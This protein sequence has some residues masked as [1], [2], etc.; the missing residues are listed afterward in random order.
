[1]AKCVLSLH[2]QA[3]ELQYPDGFQATIDL[4]F[5]P[6]PH[7]SGPLPS[8][9]ISIQEIS[10]DRYSVTGDTECPAGKILNTGELS[11]ALLED[12]VRSLIY[13][14]DTA[15]ALHAASMG[16]KGK[17]ILI[18]GP[19]GAGKTS[20]AGWFAARNFEFL[21]D[22][23]VVLS[24][25]GRTTLSFPRPLLAKPGAEQLVELL[26]GT[27]RVRAIRTAASTMFC[28]DRPSPVELKRQAG[29]II[30]PRF[31]S[32]HD[33]EFESVSPALTALKL[34]QCNL[35]A[36]NLDDHGLGALTAFA[37]NVPA[38]ALTYGS[39][40]QL[41][42]VAD[43]FAKFIL[44]SDAN[45]TGLKKLTAAFRSE[46]HS[47][48][49]VEPVISTSEAPNSAIPKSAILKSAIPEATPRKPPKKLT[50]GMATYD[51]YDGVYFTL[52]AIRMY[53]PEILDNTEFVVIDNHPDGPTAQAL[54]DLE[55]WI[56]NYR[57]VPKGDISGTAIRDCVFQEA[58]GEIVIC[59]DCHVFIAPGALKRLLA[60]FDA[61]PGTVDLLQG[62]LLYDD[63][64]SI[65][66]HFSPEW[67]QGMFGIWGSSA[68]A[69]DPERPPFDISMQGLG[70][71]ACRRE[72]WPGFNP[73]FRGFGGE[74]GYIH[75]KF[76]QR[77]GR[78]LCLPFLR[79]MH[80][81]ARPLGTPYAN[82]WEDRVRNYWIG[83]LELGWDTTPIAEHFKEYLTGGTGARIVDQ[84]E[85]EFSSAAAA[86]EKPRIS[87]DSE[88]G[89]K[90]GR[91]GS[92]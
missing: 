25:S 30:F 77:G 60:Y 84:V 78:T 6:R 38:L 65:S 27:G 36:R 81:F 17:S 79:W 63:L 29:L 39:F 68:D 89:T 92:R 73:A 49:A 56:P 88:D 16:W 74:E 8:H 90:N 76:R 1:M 71:F 75:E 83:F 5:G 91:S 2:D 9:F 70:L 31:V 82:R 57:Y 35:N 86:P 52:Q 15:V 59:M 61:H 85:K 4:L 53:H 34:M 20:L 64:T 62:P 24:G 46:S 72:A 48:V 40:G 43:T 69:A 37:R 47:A 28:V 13:R 41:D 18:P 58:S 22:E 67:R 32:G 50:I 66:T 21:S 51:D 87:G 12:V 10:P 45:V 55:N 42:G 11:D 3:I 19:T 23:L 14:L 80:R 44:E 54:K 33:L 7:E 26:E